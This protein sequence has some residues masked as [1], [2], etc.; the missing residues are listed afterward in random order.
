M[1]QQPTQPERSR[2][3]LGFG[4]GLRPQHYADLLERPDD[5]P[6][7]RVDWFEI[8]SENYMSAGGR[9]LINLD[10]VRERYPMVMHGVSLSIGSVDPLD[11]DYLDS[12]KALAERVD[13]AWIS[14]H[15][16][17]TGVDGVNLHDLLPLPYTEE[18]LAH[19]VDRIGQVQE[20][21]GRRIALENASTYVTFTNSEMSEWDFL[22]EMA[23]RADCDLLLDVNNIFVSGFNHGFDP[24]DFIEGLPA[25][26]IVQIHLAGHEHNETHIVDTHDAPVIE[27]VWSLY[28]E[29]IS[30][31]GPITTM[32]E[33]DADIPPLADMETELD[34]AR[35]IAAKALE[36][37]A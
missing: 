4:L 7:P 12:L 21:L 31:L 27:A 36:Q 35:A 1:T 24:I 11:Q 13:P 15:L 8:I 2:P 32:I 20:H 28:G 29:A 14:D 19:V 9:P 23:K 30:R 18:A 6:D 34:R 17:W 5:A 26:R 22:A 3:Y 37:A 10:R 16:C 33:R 25:E